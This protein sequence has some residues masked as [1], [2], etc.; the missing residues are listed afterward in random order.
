MAYL[1]E[2]EDPE[3]HAHFVE[4]RDHATG[5]LA[6]RDHTDLLE[7]QARHQRAKG[8]LGGVERGISHAMAAI[9]SVSYKNKRII[10]H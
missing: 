2:I 9:E 7:G 1:A 8:R 4:R 5:E 6:A 10:I 3:T